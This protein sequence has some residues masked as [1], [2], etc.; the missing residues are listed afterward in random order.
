MY[1]GSPY[2]LV[3]INNY[4]FRAL[5]DTGAETSIITPDYVEKLGL[6][7]DVKEIKDS[8]VMGVGTSKILGRISDVIIRMK[9]PESL[10]KKDDDISLPVSLNVVNM[11][12]KGIILGMDLLESIHASLS[13]SSKTLNIYGQNIKFLTPSQFKRYQYPIM[14][15]SSRDH[16]Q[17]S[18]KTNFNK[19]DPKI[20]KHI[21]TNCCEPIG[22]TIEVRELLSQ[23]LYNI[24]YLNYEIVVCE[25]ISNHISAHKY[26]EAIGLTYNSDYGTVEV[27]KDSN[28]GVLEEIYQDL[29][30]SP[31]F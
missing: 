7:A 20:S 3:E 6:T 10:D 21:K 26:L 30:D 18:G 17:L 23:I 28:I 2:I 29:I 14:I 13:I 11:S 1:S 24:I 9:N 5:I 8:I 4:L 22:F 31:Y 25:P 16:T 27:N 19:N 12:I 15:I